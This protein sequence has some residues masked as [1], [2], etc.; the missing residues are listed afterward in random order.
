MENQGPSAPAFHLNLSTALP[1]AQHLRERKNIP[2]LDPLNAVRCAC[3]HVRVCVCA[4]SMAL[5]MTLHRTEGTK[6]LRASCRATSLPSSILLRRALCVSSRISDHWPGVACMVIT[7]EEGGMWGRIS[8]AYGAGYQTRSDVR[9]L[10][11]QSSSEG[12][13]VRGS[14]FG[15]QG[16]GFGVWDLGFGVWDLGF[17]IG[18]EG[19]CSGQGFRV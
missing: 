19:T 3:I 8:V 1:K 6:S 11:P 14:G 18:V 4:C 7:W 15:V 2:S 10:P 13:G 16:S 9:L 17:A 12:F 5:G